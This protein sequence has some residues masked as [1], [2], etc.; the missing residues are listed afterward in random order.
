MHPDD[1][2][3]AGVS[4]AGRATVRTDRGEAELPVRVTEHIARGTV[5]VPFNNPGLRANVLL[6]GSF[7]TSATVEPVDGAKDGTTEPAAPDV[8]AQTV[9]AQEEVTA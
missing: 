7:R 2:E 8:T 1:A 4:D 6:S 3:A 5:F 9:T